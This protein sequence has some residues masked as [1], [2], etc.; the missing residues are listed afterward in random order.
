MAIALYQVRIHIV[1]ISLVLKLGSNL[2]QSLK[3]TLQCVR[4]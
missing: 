1:L 4:N 2:K 3:E